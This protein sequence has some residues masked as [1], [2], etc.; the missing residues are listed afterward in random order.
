[1]ADDII[2]I[3]FNNDR[4]APL[5]GGGA[6]FYNG[7]LFVDYT[8]QT[9]SGSINITGYYETNASRFDFEVSGST[10]RLVSDTDDENGSVQIRLSS[11]NHISAAVE[12][13]YTDYN[14][15]H[16][17]YTHNAP[18][19]SAAYTDSTP[20][21]V[22]GTRVLTSRGEVAVEA[23]AVGD[24]AV[25]A[26]GEER[27]IKWIGTRSYIGRFAN[28]NPDVLPICVRAGA[29]AD[30][31]PTRDLWVSPKHAL[32]L[33]A[34][35]IP[36]ELLINGTSIIKAT[37]VD[38]VTYW[39]IELDSHDVLLAEG[40]PAE[41]FVDDDGRG[42]FHNAHTYHALYP[43]APATPAVYCAPRIEHGYV[44][45]AVQRR[46]AERAGLSLPAERRFGR[47]RGRIDGCD[48][49]RVWGWAQDLAYPNA[50]VCLDV[51]VE[52]VVV[53]LVYADRHRGDLERAGIGDGRH[54]FAFDLPRP[55]AEA[56]GHTVAVRRSA[57]GE[58][59]ISAIRDAQRA[60]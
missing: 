48:G 33:D 12:A 14:T 38:S 18:V 2:S 5:D 9:V 56:I 52:G 17:W 1:M 31:I 21:Y 44:L 23:L 57:D 11:E 60:A 59:L 32:Y 42:I 16:L 28:A 19:S 7:T 25:T 26:S 15:T 35:L 43:D 55:H 41:S 27:P 37:R 46:L 13:I 20:C 29:L 50:P 54:A 8:N 39:H 47:L 4:V 45:E 22:T 36:A 40:A 34:H 6:L 51:V 58:V 30:G 24:L 53:G 3:T 10:I 49:R